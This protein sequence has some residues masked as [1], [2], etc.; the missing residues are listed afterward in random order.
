M[1]DGRGLMNYAEI[2]QQQTID[3]LL[4]RGILMGI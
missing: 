2:E 4:S 3:F 1:N